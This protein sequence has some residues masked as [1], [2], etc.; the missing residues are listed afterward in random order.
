L[1]RRR[2]D[3]G[4]AGVDDWRGDGVLD[5]CVV[6][7]AAAASGRWPALSGCLPWRLEHD[8]APDDV[9]KIPAAM[10]Q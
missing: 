9:M 10:P 7:A 2:Q 1:S 4:L 6:P 5:G 3:V 8:D